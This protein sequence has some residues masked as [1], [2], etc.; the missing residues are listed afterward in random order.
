MSV[1]MHLYAYTHVNTSS[2]RVSSFYPS[3]FVGEACVYHWIEEQID[4]LSKQ[5][6]F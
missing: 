3:L 5:V 2:W 1:S 6:N 4:I